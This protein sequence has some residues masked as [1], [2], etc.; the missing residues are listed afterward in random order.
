MSEKV[1]AARKNQWVE[2]IVEIEYGTDP[3]KLWSVLHSLGYTTTPIQ[4]NEALKLGDKTISSSL[5]NADAFMQHS[6]SR[7][8]KETPTEPPAA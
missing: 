6:S 4:P 7:R 1:A 2:L 8:E 3:R 5:K